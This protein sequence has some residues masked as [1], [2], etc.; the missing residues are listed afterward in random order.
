MFNGVLC[1]TLVQESLTH[2]RGGGLIREGAYCRIHDVF[3]SEGPPAV[4]NACN[5]NSGGAAFPHTAMPPNVTAIQEAPAPP[6][7]K[8]ESVTNNTLPRKVKLERITERMGN[9]I[10][11]GSISA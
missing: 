1:L 9:M 7:L 8:G 5:C 10:V 6:E 11:W 3:S 4:S 2:S